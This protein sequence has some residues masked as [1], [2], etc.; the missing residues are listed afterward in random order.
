[1]LKARCTSQACLQNWKNGEWV[2]GWRLWLIRHFNLCLGL[3]PGFWIKSRRVFWILVLAVRRVPSGRRANETNRVDSVR[4]Q[5]REVR[6]ADLRFT[7]HRQLPSL[8]P[9]NSSMGPRND[10]ASCRR[11]I[12]GMTLTTPPVRNCAVLR[13]R[14]LANATLIGTLPSHQ[15]FRESQQGTSELFFSESHIIMQL[16]V[17][18][19]AS[20]MDMLGLYISLS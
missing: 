8:R 4:A 3:N 2:G 7:R 11:G 6:L 5:C 14:V 17:S 9:R 18:N 10:A 16:G 13:Q 12:P 15:Y 20:H 1:M 19:M